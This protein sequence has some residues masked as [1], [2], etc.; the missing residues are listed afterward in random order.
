MENT[1]TCCK[2][3][4]SLNSLRHV[5][6]LQ[7]SQWLL[8]SC[9]CSLVLSSFTSSI[10]MF[11]EVTC[12]RKFITVFRALKRPEPDKNTLFWCLKLVENLQRVH[13]EGERTRDELFNQ[14]YWRF[15]NSLLAVQLEFSRWCSLM[16][17]R[18]WV[19]AWSVS[20]FLVFHSRYAVQV[21]TSTP[22]NVLVPASV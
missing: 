10:Q 15:C 2:S 4:N 17:G 7:F 9:S 18:K 20:R 5:G 12:R 14:E 13:C 3:Q 6:N 22:T 19:K 16:S 11:V 8:N 21:I 1:R